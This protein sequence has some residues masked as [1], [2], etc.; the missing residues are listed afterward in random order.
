MTDK[1]AIQLV[2]AVL[3]AILLATGSA[4]WAA[5]PSASAPSADLDAWT[6]VDRMGV[7]TN[8]GNTLENNHLRVII[9]CPRFIGK[10]IDDSHSQH[11]AFR[12]FF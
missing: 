8:I 11:I 7:G 6:A 12:S 5:Q 2:R 1:F 3:A 4:V 9:D 10:I